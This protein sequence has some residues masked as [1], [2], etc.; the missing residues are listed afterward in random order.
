MLLSRLLG[1]ILALAAPA[2]GGPPRLAEPDPGGVADVARVF[3]RLEGDWA[4]EGTLLGRPARFTMRWTRVL[5]GRFARLEFTNAFAAE[6]GSDPT[7]VLSAVAHYPLADAGPGRGWWFDSRGEKL[8][9]EV[10]PS[11][12]ELRVRWEGPGESGVTVYRIEGDGVVAVDSVAG[13][14]GPREF[15]RA[16]YVRRG[17]GP[18]SVSA[19]FAPTEDGGRLRYRVV[20]SG[21]EAVI[22]PM[23]SFL[24]DA[25]SPLADGRR[26]VLYDPLGRGESDATALETVTE[27]RQVRD[28]EALRAHLGLDRVALIGWSGLGKLAARYAIAHPDRVTRLVLVSPVPPSSDEYALDPDVPSRDDRVDVEALQAVRSRHEAGEF[29]ADSAAYCRAE[30]ALTLPASF[31]DP[32]LAALAPDVCRHRNEWPDLLYPYFG[33][34]LGSF[35]EFDHREDFRA[36]EIPKLVIHGREDGIPLA[37]GRGW[38]EGDANGRLLVLSPAGHFPFIERPVA[39][40]DAVDTFLGGDWPGRS[41]PVTSSAG[42]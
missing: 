33:A 37:G 28:I 15:G 17:A 6:T 26:I 41:E 39:F 36:L 30:R 2:P 13:A 21:E 22:V 18:R 16:A 40:L 9:L 5:E 12:S 20:G 42:S 35:G 1:L 38:V 4:G 31:V 34:L 11:D 3:E 25:L 14:D 7:P 24:T 32:D 29:A 8:A 10:A 27:E 23:A 19:G